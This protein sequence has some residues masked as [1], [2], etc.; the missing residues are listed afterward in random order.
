[1]RDILVSDDLISL[2]CIEG[3][4][5][6]PCEADIAILLSLGAWFF[7]VQDSPL[8]LVAHTVTTASFSVHKCSLRVVVGLLWRSLK[9]ELWRLYL[10]LKCF[11]VISMFVSS[12]FDSSILLFHTVKHSSSWCDYLDLGLYLSLSI[13]RSPF[14]SM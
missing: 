10:V 5:K 11:C 7:F 12:F 4:F 13:Y 14:L 1:M 3:I 8:C 9:L 2:Q 6:V